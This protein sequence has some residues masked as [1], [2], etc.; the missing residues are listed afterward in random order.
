MRKTLSVLIIL[1]GLFSFIIPEVKV[2][3][4][5]E[6]EK[7]EISKYIYGQFIEHLGNCIY[8]G[9]WAE[10]IQDRKFYYPI[11]DEYNP[12]RYDEDPFWNAGKFRFMGAS[13]WEVIGPKGMVMMDTVKPFTGKHSPKV[14]LDS[15]K[16]ERGIRQYEI[17]LVKGRKYKGYIYLCGDKKAKPVIVRFVYSNG[18]KIEEAFKKISDRWVKYDFSFISPASDD[19]VK[20][21]II[22]NGKGWFKI[23]TLSLMPADNINGWRR[24]VVDLLKE[25][26]APVY[27]WPGG[28]FVS[29]YNWKDGIGNRDKRPPRK[30]PAW[31]GIEPNDVGIHEFMELMEILNAE[32]YVAV[33]TGL[34]TPEEVVEEVEYINGDTSTYFGKLRAKNG[35]LNPYNVRYWAVGNEMYG[36][37]QLGH[38]PLEKYLLKHIAV[39][40]AM[41]SVDPEAELVAV[42]NVGEWTEGMLR[43]CNKFMDLMS[44]HIYCKEK[45]DVIEHASQLADN[46]RR[47]AE[48]YRKYYKDILGGKKIMIAMDEWN[49]W[50]GDYIYGELGCRYHM[51]DALG[52]ARALHEFFRNNDV[53]YMANYAQTVNVIGCI[54]TTK[55]NATFA[56]TGIVLKLY[57]NVF[58]KVPVGIKCNDDKLDVF[59]ALGKNRKY[60]TIGIVNPTFNEKEVTINLG[61]REIKKEAKVWYIQNDD[62]MAYN[63]PGKL[64]RVDIKEKIIDV[65]SGVVTIS[66]LSINIIR[67]DLD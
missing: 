4:N 7:G 56:A 23:G 35:H 21:E 31:R 8:N 51:K 48:Q 1:I 53:Y 59:A 3:I 61:D 13:P 5:L 16:E 67:I 28:N 50:Y 32:P 62:P 15:G 44:E 2:N 18:E 39:A 36:S 33:N 34:G 14:I 19:N 38:M 37:W 20:V 22:S 27:R 66:P 25:L 24:D 29:G 60:L 41:W 10:M 42:G 11:K 57:R 52:V 58:G 9:I 63:E 17:A 43:T 26:N 12:W 6:E 65:G 30:N 54:K 47:V 55:T 49:Y 40:K 46:I 45:K 64:M